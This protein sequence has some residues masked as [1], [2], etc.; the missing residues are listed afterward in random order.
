MTATINA[1][2]DQLTIDLK[3]GLGPDFTD[4]VFDFRT[5]QSEKKRA[6]AISHLATEPADKTM[7]GI[8]R[9]YEFALYMTH[10]HT[11]TLDSLRV[12][13]RGINALENQIFDTLEGSKNSLWKQLDFHRASIKPGPP[14][15]PALRY[16]AVFFRLLLK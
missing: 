16:G 1:C 2:I 3:A 12:A 6:V 13:E 9:R 8:G 4:E 5:I 10:R 15:E 7:G 11:G 14:D